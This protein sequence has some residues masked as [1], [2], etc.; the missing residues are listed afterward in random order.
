MSTTTKETGAELLARIRSRRSQNDVAAIVAFADRGLDPDDI[1]PRENVLTYRAWRAAGR[2]VAKS[3]IG[4][5]VT[6][7]IGREPQTDPE[8]GETKATRGSYPKTTRLFHVSQTIPAD[9]PKGT[10]PEAWDN[11]ALVREGEYSELQPA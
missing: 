2:Q 11:P 4:V 7:W 1:R 3:A 8:T 10:R 6:V 5:P 9:A